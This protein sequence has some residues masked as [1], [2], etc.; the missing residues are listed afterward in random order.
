[1]NRRSKIES[2]IIELVEKKESNFGS[3]IA[4]ENLNKS[5]IDYHRGIYLNNGIFIEV[6]HSYFIRLVSY[7]LDYKVTTIEELKYLTGEEQRK[8]NKLISNI[9]LYIK[10]SVKNDIFADY[11]KR[12]V[13]W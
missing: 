13:K 7:I 9:L 4:W 8:Y 2:K 6:L 1:M 5:I 12:S 10:K 3:I 11:V